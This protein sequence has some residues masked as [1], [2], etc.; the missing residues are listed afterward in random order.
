VSEEKTSGDKA[1][2]SSREA[3]RANLKALF[4]GLATLPQDVNLTGAELIELSAS[5]LNGVRRENPQA[6]HAFIQFL[7]DLFSIAPEFQPTNAKTHSKSEPEHVPLFSNKLEE[8]HSELQ[9][10]LIHVRLAVATAIA[11]E[12]QLEMQLNKC[13]EQHAS[14]ETRARMAREQR[15]AELE[16]E[17]LER[18]KRYA[19]AAMDLAAQL[20]IQKT[21]TNEMRKRLNELEADEHNAYVNTRAM[22]AREKFV[23]AQLRVDEVLNATSVNGFD[24]LFSEVERS[25]IELENKVKGGAGEGSESSLDDSRLLAKVTVTLNRAISVIEQLE[26]RLVQ[27]T[28]THGE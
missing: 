22:I 25:V 27:D 17:A 16:E 4:D 26:K 5:V 1:E 20:K 19:D 28:N 14:W 3:E 13:K 23:R 10:S 21:S 8:K 18:G 24:N 9:E 15:S 2:L 12:K 7:R 6:W 11:T